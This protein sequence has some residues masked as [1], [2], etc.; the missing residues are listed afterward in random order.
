MKTK[1]KEASE[2]INKLK[3]NLGK[4]ETEMPSFKKRVKKV[5]NDIDKLKIGLTELINKQ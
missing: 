3:T 2:I 5:S 4:L 1:S